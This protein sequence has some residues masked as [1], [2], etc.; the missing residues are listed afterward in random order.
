MLDNGGFF[1][2]GF[3]R[4]EPGQRHQISVRSVFF[5]TSSREMAFDNIRREAKNNKILKVMSFIVLSNFS[6]IKIQFRLK[7]S[8]H[9]S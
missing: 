5:V 1:S 7:I 9:C 3:S 8:F 2:C 4:V 6:S